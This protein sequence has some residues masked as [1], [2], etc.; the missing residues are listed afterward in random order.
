MEDDFSVNQ[1]QE[2]GFRMIQARYIYCE[3]YLHYYYITSTSDHQAVNPR[4]WSRSLGIKPQI[5]RH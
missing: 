4:G 1:R 3:L 2:D 5:I